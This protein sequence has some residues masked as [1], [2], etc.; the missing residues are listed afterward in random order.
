MH[1]CTTC[2]G[3]GAWAYQQERYYHQDAYKVP[4]VDSTCAGDTFTG[5]YMRAYL[6]GCSIPQALKI[7][8]KAASFSVQKQGAAI[9]IPSWEE[10][11]EDEKEV[12]VCPQ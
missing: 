2:G 9:S 8:C 6:S 12:I 1:I 7:A 5:F 3:D 10:V 4:V 11:I